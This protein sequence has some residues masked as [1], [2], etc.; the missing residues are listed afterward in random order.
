ALDQVLR[1]AE[2]IYVV[3]PYCHGGEL[4]RKV[5]ANRRLSEDIARPMFRGLLAGMACLHSLQICHRDMSLEN[6]LLTEHDE[7]KIIDFGMVLRFGQQQAQAHGGEDGG[8]AGAFDGDRRSGGSDSS[9]ARSVSPTGPF[10]KKH[11][12]APEVAMNQ[13]IYDGFAVDIWAVGIIM[14]I[15]LAGFPPFRTPIPGEDE[16]CHFIAVDRRLLDLAESWHLNLSPQV[17]ER[18]QKDVCR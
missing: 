9:S 5:S 11:Y 2:Y 6:I 13:R 7:V 14:F 4:F 3:L 18:L 8:G 12:M 1:D 15:T 10:G 17:I 16:R